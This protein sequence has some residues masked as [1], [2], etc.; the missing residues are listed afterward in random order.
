MCN[1]STSRWKA[2]VADASK[3]LGGS[4]L[5]Y[6]IKQAQIY[7]NDGFKMCQNTSCIH[8]SHL[9]TNFNAWDHNHKSSMYVCMYV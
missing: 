5:S 7:Y 8:H 4:Q 6:V 1:H 9:P 3:F 2:G